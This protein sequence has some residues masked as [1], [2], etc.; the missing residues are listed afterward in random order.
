MGL[1]LLYGGLAA[2]RP[3]TRCSPPSTT[4]TP[5]TSRCALRAVRDG[6]TVR[7]V[8]LY[9]DPA[10]ATSPTRSWPGCAPRVTPAHAG[11]RGD[12]GALQHRREAADPGDGRR[13]GRAN[14][15]GPADGRC[16]ASTG[17]TGSA[18]V[19][20]DAGRA[21]L[22]LP[23]LRQPQ[24][25]VRAARHRPHLGQRARL[26]AVHARR[27][28]RSPPRASASGWASAPRRRRPAR[29]RRRAATTASSTG[30]RSPRRSTCT[31]AIGRDRVAARTRDLADPAQGRPRRDRRGHA[32]SPRATPDLS[33]GVVCCQ[34]RR[35]PPARRCTGCGRPRWS[36]ARPRTAPPTCGSAPPS[37][38]TRNRWTR[39]CAR[40]AR[41]CEARGIAVA[42]MPVAPDPAPELQAYADPRRLVTTEWLA[43]QP[44]R[45]RPRGRRVR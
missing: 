31:T 40:F 10:T 11:R 43:E 3:A 42:G 9:D 36:R 19:D 8:R 14:A 1:G 7:R 25:A 4:S 22:R 41:W 45:R 33:A 2:A 20:A 39:R 15:T 34:C 17:C 18:P 24:V 38:T 5:P 16:S 23:R 30:G 21:R 37:S 13:A 44:R 12:L 6:V 29:P 28:R 26:G 35:R 27:S 32:A